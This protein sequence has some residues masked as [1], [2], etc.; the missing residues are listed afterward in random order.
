VKRNSSIFLMPA[1]LLLLAAGAAFSKTNDQSLM[2]VGTYTGQGSEGIYAYRFDSKTGALT[3]LGLAAPVDNPSFLAIAPNMKNLYAVS[4]GRDGA[5]SAFTIDP[6]TGK[7]TV[8]NRVSTKGNGPCFVSTD[9]TGRAAFIANY[10]SGSVAS[11]KIEDGGRL[12]EAVSFIQ[13]KGASADKSRQ[14][15]PH[16]HSINISP[17]NH[18][19]V[20]AD[21]GIDELLVYQLDPDTA[22]L[23]PN[24]PPFTKLAPGDGPRHFT[25][26]P[27]GR[28]AYVIN[29]ISSTVTAFHWDAAKGE[30]HAIET[31]STLPPE[32]KPG[33]S[34]AE[35][36]VHPNGKFL[37]GSNRGH[38]SIAVF[39]IDQKTG[40]LKLVQNA[41]TGGNL[42]RNFR[43]DPTGRWLIAANMKG[44]NM[45]VFKIDQKSGQLTATGS[46]VQLVS[47]VCIK[48]IPAH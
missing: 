20:A 3:P 36:Q 10:G 39:T 12:S 8:I 33:N 34:T 32:G 37:Y 47:P 38:D 43:I 2:Y 6:S 4:E 46:P 48:F 22:R 11:Y 42:P 40:K 1:V 5:V 23:T 27:N 31:L 16:A 30:L 44:N 35:V 9:K 45:T 24:N 29:E 13:H 26:H 18:F 21:L 28:Y 17:D 14:N 15:A 25:F 19:A 41:P 7:L